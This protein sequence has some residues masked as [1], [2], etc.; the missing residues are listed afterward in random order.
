MK[1]RAFSFRK[2]I[3]SFRFAGQG[4]RSLFLDEPNA[5]IHLIAVLV[6][7]LGGWYFQIRTWEWV[8]VILCFALVISMELINTAIENMAD[9]VSPEYD[10]RIGKIK[11]QAAAAVL[12]SAMMAF[13][14]G[15]IIFAPKVG[16]LL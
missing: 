8:S 2:M 14:V 1:F 11:D 12:F 3:S 15:L 9:F 16:R 4:F 7:A 10:K 13:I 6:V 5:R